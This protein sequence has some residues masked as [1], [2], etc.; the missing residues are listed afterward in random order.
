MGVSVVITT[1]IFIKKIPPSLWCLRTKINELPLFVGPDERTILGSVVPD[2][3]ENKRRIAICSEQKGQVF[4][5]LT[6]KTRQL[7]LLFMNKTEKF[8]FT[9]FLYCIVNST[10]MKY[11]YIKVTRRDSPCSNLNEGREEVPFIFYV[12]VCEN[13][14]CSIWDPKDS[15][16]ENCTVD[17][18]SFFHL[19]EL[20]KF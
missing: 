6:D 13:M 16:V 19:R 18:G 3:E 17:R 1:V 8:S 5:C 4:F 2:E 10:K 7:S 11:N 15:S 12:Y 14:I 20:N 9:D